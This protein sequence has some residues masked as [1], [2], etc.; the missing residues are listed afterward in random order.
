ML[1]RPE[2]GTREHMLL[3]L[4]SQPPEKTYP[5]A[6]VTKCACAIYARETM[7]K[8]N[9]WWTAQASRPGPFHALNCLA[10]IVPHTYG[11]L[12]ARALAAWQK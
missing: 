3:W 5:W 11:A 12:H 8:S 6:L 4:A 2:P 1:A 7:G 10:A 9:L